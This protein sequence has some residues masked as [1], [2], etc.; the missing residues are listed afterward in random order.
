MLMELLASGGRAFTATGS[1]VARVTALRGLFFR[2]SLLV[3]RTT[4]HRVRQVSVQSLTHTLASQHY[5]FL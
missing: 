1:A 4:Y 3:A 2:K 5:N